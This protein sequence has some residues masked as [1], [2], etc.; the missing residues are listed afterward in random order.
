MT[1]SGSPYE[2]T[3]AERVNGIIKNEFLPKKVYQN[4]KEVKKCIVAIIG[5]Y[6]DRRPHASLNY[7]TPDQ[8]H[9]MSGEIKKR[10]RDIRAPKKERKKIRL[11]AF[12]T[13]LAKRK[14]EAKKEKRIR[15]WKTE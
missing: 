15:M 14:K 11:L 5:H 1:Q 4:H 9:G 12:K 3:F 8:A 2:N 7:H 6:K 13:V 10:W